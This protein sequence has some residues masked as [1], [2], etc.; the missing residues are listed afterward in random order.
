[1]DYFSY[2]Y[3]VMRL[4]FSSIV[5]ITLKTPIWV[6]NYHRNR[7]YTVKKRQSRVWLKETNEKTKYN[8][9]CEWGVKRNPMYFQYIEGGAV[10]SIRSIKKLVGGTSWVRTHIPKTRCTENRWGGIVR[11]KSSMTNWFA[12]E[13]LRETRQASSLEK[14]GQF[15]P[16]AQVWT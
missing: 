9:N 10:P 14:V 11:T 4:R 7:K 13:E 1:M 5:T 15:Y 6:R 16:S 12:G 8:T 2:L 3:Y